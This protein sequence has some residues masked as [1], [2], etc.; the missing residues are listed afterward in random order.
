MFFSLVIFLSLLTL[1]FQIAGTIV[2]GVG[3]WLLVDMSS[4][5]GLLKVVP[6]DKLEVRVN[7]R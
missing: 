7:K 6:A 2:L 1:F 5:I 4:F 3:I